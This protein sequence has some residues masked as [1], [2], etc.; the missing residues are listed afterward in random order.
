[1]N[2]V[3]LSAGLREVRGVAQYNSVEAI[4]RLVELIK[5]LN[6]ELEELKRRSR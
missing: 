1:M 6:D 3:E 2:R 5:D 4:E